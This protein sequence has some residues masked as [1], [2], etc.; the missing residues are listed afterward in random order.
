MDLKR[1]GA[2]GYDDILGRAKAAKGERAAMGR[3]LQSDEAMWLRQ[4]A[5]TVGETHG[6]VL[7]QG[8]VVVVVT[9]R[10]IVAA[11]TS[12]GFRPHWE[13]FTLPFGHLEPGV[14]VTGADRTDVSIPTSGQRSYYVELADGESAARLAAAL[15]DA[16]RAY[17]RDRMG[18]PE[19]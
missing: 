15:A 16:L 6:R 9:D 17:R 3:Y 18:L 19:Q 12:G 1:V 5:E 7:L 11:R 13:A 8:G 10:K 2:D 4:P 14:L